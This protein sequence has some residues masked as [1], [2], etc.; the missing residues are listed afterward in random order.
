MTTAP[1]RAGASWRVAA[2]ILAS[3]VA[4]LVREGV[5]AHFF[6]ASGVADAWRAALRMPNFLQNLLGEGSLSASF[7]PIYSE[8]LEE[9]REE[10]ASRLAGAILGLLTL[11]AGL[12]AVLG[13][14]LA[15]ILVAVIFAGFDPERQATTVGLVRILFPMTALLVVSAWAL[16]VLNS[17]RR[18]FLPYVAPVAW[19][20]AMIAAMVAGGVAWGLSGEELV[21][22][23]AWGALLG[24][25]LQLGVQ[26]PLVMRLVGEF[27]PSLSL[28]AFGVREAIRNFTPVVAARGV[29]NLSGYL[30]YFLAAFLVTGSVAMIG[31]AQTL[32]LLPIALFGMSVAASELPELSR[33][34]G[35]DR[36]RFAS[37]LS[38]GMERVAYFLIPSAIGY[39]VL[40]DVIVAAFF[41]RGAFGSD[42]VQVAWVVLGSYAVGMPAS[43]TS[44]LLSSSFYAL[45]DT[46]TPARIAYLRIAASLLVGLALIFPLD[47]VRVGELSLGPAGLALGASAGAWLEFILLRISLRRAMGPHGVPGGRLGRMLIA[48]GAALLVAIFCRPLLAGLVP[49]VALL[50]GVGGFAII[51]LAGT[52][53]LGVAE[54]LRTLPGLRGRRR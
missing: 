34:R 45:R 13:I 17:H 6:G 27:R 39:L 9:G 32:Y 30:D 20:G 43:A 37:D 51:Y 24:G 38:R 53:V 15:P 12:L 49:W 46:R 11:T 21:R 5:F 33:E 22:V 41:Q 48:G 28:D 40:G 16:G 54:P 36:V 10:D 29:V 26:L 19:N 25:A 52:W 50:V 44:R 3:R 4:G 2:G 18:F 35:V 47:Q 8:L 14:L 1:D 7:I 42:A 23:L 31:Y